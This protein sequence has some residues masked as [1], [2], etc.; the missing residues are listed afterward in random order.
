MDQFITWFFNLV[1][2][3]LGNGFDTPGTDALGGLLDGSPAIWNGDGSS[4][5][6][7]P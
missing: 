6:L 1:D 4:P 2:S 7:T 5:V 3:A